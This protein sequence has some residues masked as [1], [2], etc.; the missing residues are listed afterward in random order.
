MKNEEIHALA[1]AAGVRMFGSW[2]EG[3]QASI[4]RFAELIIESIEDDRRADTE[5]VIEYCLWP[6]GTYCER[7]ELHEMEWMSDDYIVI[8]VNE[9]EP[10][11]SPIFPG[12][13][14]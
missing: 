2:I 8:G 4:Y 9:W 5:L 1:E 6:D 11:G 7:N 10:D 3:S 13:L 14:V 12:G